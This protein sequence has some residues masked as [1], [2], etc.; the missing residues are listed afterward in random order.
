MLNKFYQ[1]RG[2]W[3]KAI[4]TADGHDRIH[5]RSTYYSYAQHLENTGDKTLAL[6]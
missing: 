5:L 4:E 3:Q 2:D 6:T 1:A